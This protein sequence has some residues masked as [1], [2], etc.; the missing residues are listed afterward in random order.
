NEE[1]INVLFLIDIITIPF[2]DNNNYVVGFSGRTTG[3]SSTKYLNTGTTKIFNKGNVLFNFNR[4][5]E[6]NDKKIIIVEGFMDAIALHNCNHKNVVATMGVALTNKHLNLL[7]SL[8]LDTV[9]LCFDNDNAGQLATIENGT[10]LMTN[11]FNVYVVNKYDS[12]IKDVDELMQASGKKAVDEIIENRR[13]FISYLISIKLPKCLPLDEVQTNTNYILKQMAEYSDLLL[14]NYHFKQISELTG[15]S[16]E[17]LSDK[18]N[19]I[20]KAKGIYYS[21]ATTPKN[22]IAI[23]S[24]NLTYKE[25]VNQKIKDLDESDNQ[26]SKIKADIL[27]NFAH[28]FGVQRLTNGLVELIGFLLVHNDYIEKACNDDLAFSRKLMVFPQVKIFTKILYLYE[29]DKH[30]TFDSLKEFLTVEPIEG[31]DEQ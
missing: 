27:T 7:H 11:G 13:D 6:L 2:Y 22:D 4:V 31:V 15:L 12:K 24:N 29:R 8:E 18:L 26:N 16:V 3:N 28:N 1:S 19:Q 21:N 5:R 9:I 25:I 30:V 14:R 10:R 23:D 17:D 20:L